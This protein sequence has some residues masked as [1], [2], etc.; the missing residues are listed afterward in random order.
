VA[1]ILGP[2]GL[3]PNPKLGTVTVNIVDAVKN[4]KAGQVEFRADKGGIVHAG[5][6]KLSFDSDKLLDN[7]KA[8]FD[9]I[10]KA[11]PAASKGVYIKYAFVSATMS[12]ALIVQTSSLE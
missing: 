9:A 4:S 3:M 2:K 11:K 5:V 12:P 8:L 6:G 1:K 10:L 7:A